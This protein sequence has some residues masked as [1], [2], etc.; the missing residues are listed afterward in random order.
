ME[1]TGDGE[2]IYALWGHVPGR[3]AQT[4]GAAE[5]YAFWMLARF[6]LER[7]T[8]CESLPPTYTDY[9]RLKVGLEAGEA[10]TVG[11]DSMLADLWEG[12]WITLRA[13]GVAEAVWPIIKVKAHIILAECGSD[14]RLLWLRSCNEWSDTYAKEG[15]K[16]HGIPESF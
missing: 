1:V 4:S 6:H 13:L 8:S 14:S 2:L 3:W 11:E 15:A 10:A 12:I 16:L 7:G 9:K 5:L